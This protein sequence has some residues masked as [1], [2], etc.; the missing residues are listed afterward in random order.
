MTNEKTEHPEVDED[1]GEIWDSKTDRLRELILTYQ[2]RF[3]F[4]I[5][6][7]CT[8]PDKRQSFSWNGDVIR[9]AAS[10]IKLYIFG[11][12][13]K[14]ITDGDIDRDDLFTMRSSNHVEGSGLL[15]YMAP[16][17][18]LKLDELIY[19]MMA[20]SDNIAANMIIDIVSIDE[21]QKFILETGAKNTQMLVP[22]MAS[23]S[24][25][26]H[27]ENNVTT[28]NDV[29]RIY[30][31]MSSGL[32]VEDHSQDTSKWASECQYILTASRGTAQEKLKFMVSHLNWKG[33]QRVL[34]RNLSLVPRYL[35]VALAIGSRKRLTANLPNQVVTASKPGTGKTVFHDSCLLKIEI[36]EI[37]LAVMISCGK[38]NFAKPQTEEYKGA[39]DFCAKLSQIVV[40]D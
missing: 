2:Q 20:Y 8:K 33:L 7:T 25:R 37:I 28:T 3:N 15:K 26:E 34:R 22:M 17:I 5:S 4:D 23:P 27:G 40:E 36:S 35:K 12:V 31:S 10:L 18:E 30:E 13:M 38:A 11:A 32:S 9:P 21:I 24:Q 39:C 16:P 1:R 14:R 6:V 19:L 29:T